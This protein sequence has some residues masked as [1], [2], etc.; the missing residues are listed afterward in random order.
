MIKYICILCLIVLLSG[1]IDTRINGCDGD[2]TV[3][4]EPPHG[5]IVCNNGEK[6]YWYDYPH[7]GREFR[8]IGSC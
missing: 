7:G 6:G 4:W 3:C 2:G 5:E 1:C 8:G